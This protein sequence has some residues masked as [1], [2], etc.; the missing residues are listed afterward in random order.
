M[1]KRFQNLQ[2]QRFGKLVA[3]EFVEI[4]KNKKS[5]W[6]FKC[7]CGNEKNIIVSNVKNGRTSSCGCEHKKQL[8]NRVK[9]HGYCVAK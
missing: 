7:D 1:S 5:V 8:S 6:R 3:I 9:K 2:G 4:N